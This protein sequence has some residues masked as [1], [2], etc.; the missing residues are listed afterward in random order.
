MER[1]ETYRQIPKHNSVQLLIF[2]LTTVQITNNNKYAS[3][4]AKLFNSS[5]LSHAEA[6]AETET[7]AG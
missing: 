2:T 4:C 5:A 3:L 6:E 7:G 1:E